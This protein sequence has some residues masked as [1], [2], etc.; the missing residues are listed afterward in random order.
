MTINIEV[1]DKKLQYNI[2]SYAANTSALSYR[3]FD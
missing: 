2:N 1:R 3:K